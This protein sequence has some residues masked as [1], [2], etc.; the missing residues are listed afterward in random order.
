MYIRTKYSNYL[1]MS[2]T[3]VFSQT[4]RDFGWSGKHEIRSGD[5]G[6]FSKGTLLGVIDWSDPNFLGSDHSLICDSHSPYLT[7]EQINLAL[8]NITKTPHKI[9]TINNR[10]YYIPK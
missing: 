4:R 2:K 9:K 3:Q 6:I 5:E 7:S 8:T 10:L 1:W